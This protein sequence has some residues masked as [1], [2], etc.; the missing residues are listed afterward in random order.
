VILVGSLCI[1]LILDFRLGLWEWLY[2]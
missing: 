1:W 2:L